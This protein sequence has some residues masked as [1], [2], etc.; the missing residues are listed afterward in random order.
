MKRRPRIKKCATKFCKNSVSKGTGAYC[1]TCKS[2]RWRATN[3]MR[4][5]YNNLKSNAKRRHKPFDIDFEYFAEFC[6]K[7]DYLAGRGRKKDCY[8]VDCK[9]NELGYV[10]G[11]LQ[12]LTKSEN[13]RKGTKVLHFDWQTRQAIVV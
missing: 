5:C 4:Y 9:I 6:V 8:T 10:K 2:R 7:N 13:S 1:N 3:V 12:R 11:N